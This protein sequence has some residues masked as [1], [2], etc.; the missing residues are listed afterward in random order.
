MNVR[1]VA[2][3][4][5]WSC[6][7]A[8]FT[9][10]AARKG[11]EN[12]GLAAARPAAATNQPPAGQQTGAT[13]AKSSPYALMAQCSGPMVQFKLQNLT[14]NDLQVQGKDFAL[15]VPG[16]SRKVIPYEQQSVT[17]D[18][19]KSVVGPNETIEGR[20]VFSENT[21]PSGC[22]L[23]FK[24]YSRPNDRGTYAQIQAANASL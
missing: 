23:V 20:A 18:L 3:Y 24:P 2:S 12:I 7:V 8:G 16:D 1:K 4:V 13:G 21:S 14:G 22:R 9:G 15:V 6:L 19:P 17:V 11:L 10:C 5:L